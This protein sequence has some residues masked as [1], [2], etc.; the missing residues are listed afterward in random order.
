MFSGHRYVAVV[1]Q[2]RRLVDIVGQVGGKTA[3][4]AQVH[5]ADLF[6][7]SYITRDFGAICGGVTGVLP[8]MRQHAVCQ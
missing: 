2:L 8:A 7:Q 6:A 4:I 1:E 5:A 3:H